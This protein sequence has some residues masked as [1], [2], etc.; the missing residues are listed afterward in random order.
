MGWNVELQWKSRKILL[1][2]DCYAALFEKYPTG[3][4]VSQH[5]HP[6]YR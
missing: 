2:L 4:S 6:W 3:I 5:Q 1:G